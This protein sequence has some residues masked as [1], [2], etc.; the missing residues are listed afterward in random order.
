MTVENIF[1]KKKELCQCVSCGQKVKGRQAQLFYYMNMYIYD[2]REKKN[3]LE[4]SNKDK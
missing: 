3:V 2:E 1:S 4:E